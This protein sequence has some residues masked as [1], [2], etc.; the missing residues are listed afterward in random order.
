[1]RKLLMTIG[2]ILFLAAPALAGETWT[3]QPR[4]P[5][6]FPNNGVFDA[7]TRQNPY[8]LQDS[9]GRTRAIIQPRYY[10]FIPDDG[11]FDAGGYSNPMEIEILD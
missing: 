1:M 8:E 5:D 7:G 4:L 10:D 9:C 11:I 3:V 6:F 2:L